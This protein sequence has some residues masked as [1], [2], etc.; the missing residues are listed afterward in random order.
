MAF[1]LGQMPMPFAASSSSRAG[2]G[3]GVSSASGFI[4][5]LYPAWRATQLDP[6]E[7]LRYE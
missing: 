3:S 4:F 1:I 5:G 7:A 2:P 6:T